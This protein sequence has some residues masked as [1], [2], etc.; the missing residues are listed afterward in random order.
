MA[1]TRVKHRLCDKA[2]K[3]V[4]HNAHT[5]VLKTK[6]YGGKDKAETFRCSGWK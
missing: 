5:Y 3:H 6:Y 4:K 1:Q 2:V